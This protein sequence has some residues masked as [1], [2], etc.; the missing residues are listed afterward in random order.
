MAR[1]PI[2]PSVT[3]TPPPISEA[4]ST[5]AP[6]AENPKETQQQQSSS[7]ASAPPPSQSHQPEQAKPDS[8]EDFTINVSKSQVPKRHY[9]LILAL[10]PTYR[11]EHDSLGV[12]SIVLATKVWEKT[13]IMYGE[14]VV[15][16]VLWR[17]G[18]PQKDVRMSI[19]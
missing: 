12:L 3:V 14:E 13:G 17:G 10:F 4:A 9:D 5:P 7:S 15:E 16:E 18:L 1:F 8:P 6:P 19:F 2:A 11:K